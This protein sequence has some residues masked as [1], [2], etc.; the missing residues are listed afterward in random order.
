MLAS[1]PQGIRGVSCAVAVLSETNDDV[2]RE[3][4]A[5]IFK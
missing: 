1:Q 2:L 5:T 3:F 4:Q